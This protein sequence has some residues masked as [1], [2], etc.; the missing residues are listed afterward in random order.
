MMFSTKTFPRYF[1]LNLHIEA[2][3]SSYLRNLHFITTIHNSDVTLG[4]RF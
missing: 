1:Q 3:L 4:Y 2:Q